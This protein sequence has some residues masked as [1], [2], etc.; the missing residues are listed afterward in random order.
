MVVHARN[1]TIQWKLWLTTWI[2]RWIRFCISSK[3]KN[4]G[5]KVDEF[6]SPFQ[7]KSRISAKRGRMALSNCSPLRSVIFFLN[8]GHECTQ[9][10]A[11]QDKNGAD[12]KIRSFIVSLASWLDRN[13]GFAAAAATAAAIRLVFTARKSQPFI[14][15]P[16]I[17]YG[18]VSADYAVRLPNRSAVE[19][20]PPFFLLF[21]FFLCFCCSSLFWPLAAEPSRLTELWK[22]RWS[23]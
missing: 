16:T 22:P 10:A 7:L 20:K 12:V 8:N 6:G 23:T 19:R 11:F 18:C 14:S 1:D 4:I 5:R 3:I 21:S 9:N 15:G 17:G 13:A 2:I